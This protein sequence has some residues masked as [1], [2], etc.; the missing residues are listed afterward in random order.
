M[1]ALDSG[2]S[3]KMTP[4]PLT[5]AHSRQPCGPALVP[6]LKSGTANDAVPIW[7]LKLKPY[8]LNVRVERGLATRVLSRKTAFQ[9]SS[10]A[11]EAR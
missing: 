8:L 6:G 3:S 10:T 2:A 5:Y 1:R 7:R 4:E 9:A 11:V